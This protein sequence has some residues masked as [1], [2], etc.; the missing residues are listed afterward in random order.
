[1]TI[2]NVNQKDLTNT[3]MISN[4]S[5]MQSSFNTNDSSVKAQFVINDVGHFKYLRDNSL[6]I[7]FVDKVKLFMEDYSLQ[8]YLNNELESCCCSIYLL[9]KSQHEIYLGYL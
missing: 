5:S 4:A 9:D 7:F 2:E 3:S 6:A 8:M 1:M